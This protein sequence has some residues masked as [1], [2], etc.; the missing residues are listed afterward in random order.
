MKA[1]VNWIKIIMR[2]N[3]R[4]RWKKKINLEKIVMKLRGL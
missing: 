2:T 1:K 3:V 4:K